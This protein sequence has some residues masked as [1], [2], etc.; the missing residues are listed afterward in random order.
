MMRNKFFLII[1]LVVVLV[2]CKPEIIKTATIINNSSYS[3]SFHYSPKHGGSNSG[4][5]IIPNS[6]QTVSAT[7]EKGTIAEDSCC[8][9]VR[10]WGLVVVNDTMEL[11]KEIV[12]E[13]SWLR[14]ITEKGKGGEVNCTFEFYDN[15]ISKK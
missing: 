4:Y 10:D 3:V 6:T 7:T 11:T 9:C 12:E 14:E 15:D 5:N 1:L 13:T 8:A 2:A